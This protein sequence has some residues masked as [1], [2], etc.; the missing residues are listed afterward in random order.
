MRI[1]IYSFFLLLPYPIF[2]RQTAEVRARV[3]YLYVNEMD[4]LKNGQPR[5]EKMVLFTGKNASLYTSEDKINYE[6][7]EDQKSKARALARAAEGSAPLAVFIDKSAGEWLTRRNY[8]FFFDE[9][10]HYVKETLF[11]HYLIEEVFATPQWTLLRDTLRIADIRCQ[12]AITQVD[13]E[14][15]IAWFAQDLPF[16]SG[17]WKLNGLPGLIIQAENQNGKIKFQFNGFAMSQ[18]NEFNRIDDVRK[19]PRYSPG[20]LNTID[21]SMGT[22]VAAAYFDLRIELP[23]YETVA[24]SRKNF[25]QLKAAYLKDPKGFR[26]AIYGF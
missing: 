9:R 13:G 14:T 23:S 26:K 1:F 20:A 6:R 16:Q 24:T 12:K 18:V 15:W 3:H 11:Q 10:K 7:S 8:F 4:T 17:P 21:V 19:S 5:V 25:E 22:E 2:A